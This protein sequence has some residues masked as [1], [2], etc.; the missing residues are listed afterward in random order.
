M[1]PNE[2]I[3]EPADLRWLEMK[4]KENKTTLAAL[5]GQAVKRMRQE[6]DKAEYPS[7]EL[8]LEQTR[9]IWKGSDGLEYQQI[10]RGE[11]A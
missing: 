4:A 5:I 2:I 7:F 9:G 6:E 3:L 8:L 10:I 1:S 11:W